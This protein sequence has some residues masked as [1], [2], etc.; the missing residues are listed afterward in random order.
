MEGAGSRLSRASS[1]YGPTTTVFS[2]PVRRWKKKWVHVPPSPSSFS[3]R[4]QSN[5]R[6]NDNSSRL[7]LCRWTPISS[8]PNSAAAEPGSGEERPRRKF[9][10]TPVVLLEEQRKAVE[11][12]IEDMEDAENASEGDQSTVLSDKMYGKSNAD[13]VK[14]QE[15]EEL[16]NNGSQAS[17]INNL[18]LDLGLQGHSGNLELMNKMKEAQTKT[19]SSGGFWLQ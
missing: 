1:R 17:S 14:E 3:S 11:K 5:A 10:Y 7:L 9:R 12:R 8:A 16:D 18:N 6:N 15:A 19:A 13:Q 4:S 2:G